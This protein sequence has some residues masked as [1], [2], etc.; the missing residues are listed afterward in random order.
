[1][2][3]VMFLASD[4]GHLAELLVFTPLFAEYKTTI[5]LEQ[6]KRKLPEGPKYYFL[7]K[8][9]RKQLFRYLFIFSW[10]CLKSIFIYCKERPDAIITTGAHTTVPLSLLG[11][12]MRKQV[13]FIESIAR[14]NS[15][16]LTGKILERFVSKIL[17]QWPTMLEVYPEAEYLGPIL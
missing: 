8:G 1:M 3:K 10:I 7:A 14:V 9:T 16:S 12:L 2:K 17:V 11:C 4:G 5:V 6:T 13:I 15:K